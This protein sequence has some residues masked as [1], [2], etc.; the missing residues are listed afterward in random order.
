MRRRQ[1]VEV[2]HVIWPFASIV[3]AT[4]GVLFTLTIVEPPS[5]TSEFIIDEDNGAI[6]ACV[7]PWSYI[8]LDLLML[9]AIAISVW[10]AYLT[11]DLPEDI[12]DAKR[13]WQTLL[14][15]CFI[16]MGKKTSHDTECT[17]LLDGS[18]AQPQLPSCSSL[19]ERFSRM[20]RCCLRLRLGLA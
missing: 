18:N 10:Q 11:R 6:G 4:V 12:S 8:V 17:Q 1:K 2:K 5:W 9:L 19:S 15:H 20:R 16:I 7:D 14:A 3:A 13:V